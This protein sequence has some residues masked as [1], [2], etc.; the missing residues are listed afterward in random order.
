MGTGSELIADGTVHVDGRPVRSCITP[1]GL[2]RGASA[3]HADQNYE[4]PE[5]LEQRQQWHEQGDI[6]D[7][8]IPG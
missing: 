1:V 8:Q 3:Q 2:D 7:R 6:L 5:Q 4:R